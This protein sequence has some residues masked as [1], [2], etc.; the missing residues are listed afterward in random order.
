MSDY[1]T[2]ANLAAARIGTETRISSPDDDRFVARTIKAVWDIQ[3]Q[4]AI[5]DGAW[6]FAGRRAELAAESD[7]DKVIYPWDYGFPLPEKC[8][9]LIE[10]LDTSRDDYMLEGDTILANTIGPL[11]IRYLVDVEEPA[12]WDAGFAESFALRLAW[13]TGRRIAGSAFDQ[14]QCQMEYRQSLSAA[15]RVDARENPG[16]EQ[17]ESSWITARFGASRI[18]G[19]RW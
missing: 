4:A 15:K 12:R 14:D 17:E 9:R 16:I 3:R 13:R 11:Y 2:I 18:P 10:V 6:N 19:Q 8:L 1:V 7:P 5:R